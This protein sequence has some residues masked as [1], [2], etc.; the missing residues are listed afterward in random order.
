[1]TAATLSQA[2]AHSMRCARCGEWAR[3][4][5]VIEAAPDPERWQH[6]VCVPGEGDCA[7]YGTRHVYALTIEDCRVV[8]ACAVCYA[9][10]PLHRDTRPG[11]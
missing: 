2:F 10:R 4:G 3:A 6:Q 11:A 9:P 5:E 1:M 7:K 8:E